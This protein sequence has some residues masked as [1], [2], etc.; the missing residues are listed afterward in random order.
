LLR[1]IRAVHQGENAFDP[2][3]SPTMVRGLTAGPAGGEQTLTAREIEVLQLLA[4]GM[5]NRDIR[6]ALFIAGTTAKF[7]VANIMRKLDV[8]RHSEAVYVA[9]Q[10]GAI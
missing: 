5:S 1:A 10:M 3:S 8:G 7:Q 2:R 9:S 6:R 4:L